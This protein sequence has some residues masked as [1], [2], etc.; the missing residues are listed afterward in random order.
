MKKIL[1][2]LFVVLT[3]VSCNSNESKMKE[4]NIDGQSF[5]DNYIRKSNVIIDGHEY[6]LFEWGSR[7]TFKG[8]YQFQL[9]HKID[10]KTCLDIFD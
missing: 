3:I 8:N 10:C 2:S 4:K 1:L 5:V 7:T 6:I 9:E